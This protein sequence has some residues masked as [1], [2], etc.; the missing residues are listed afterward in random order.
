VVRYHGVERRLVGDLSALSQIQLVIADP[1][2]QCRRPRRR[3]A[4]LRGLSLI[5]ATAA[6]GT[7]RPISIAVSMSQPS[8]L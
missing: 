3:Q 1:E 5:S 7:S 4:L 8:S 2:S 6:S